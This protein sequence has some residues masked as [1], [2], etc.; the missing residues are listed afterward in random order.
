MPFLIGDN[1]HLPIDDASAE[2]TP[3]QIQRVWKLIDSFLVWRRKEERKKPG[4]EGEVQQ[5]A[6]DVMTE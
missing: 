5:K 6:D 4:P 1:E 3:S 2:V